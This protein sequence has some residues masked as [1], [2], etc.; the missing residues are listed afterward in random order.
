VRSFSDRSGRRRAALARRVRGT[1]RRGLVTVEASTQWWKRAVVYQVYPRSF[2]DSDGDGVGDLR[3]VIAKLDYLKLLGVDVVWLSPVYP[4]PGDDNGYDISDYCDIAPEFGTLADWDELRDGLHARGMRLVM[5]LVVN[6]TSDDHPW[7]QESR[8]SVTSPRRDWYIWRR[9]PDGRPPNNWGSLFSGSAWEYDEKT[10]EHYLHLFS[11]RMPD[12][13]WANPHVRAAV[14][15]VMRWWLDRG[16]DGFRMDVINLIAKDPALPSTQPVDAFGFG[17]FVLDPDRCHAYLREVRE[18]VLAGRDV[19]TIGETPFSTLEEARRFTDPRRGELDM[20][21]P[22]DHMG[23]DHG[24]GG[25]YDIRPLSLPD[26]KRALSRWQTGLEGQGWACLYWNNHDQPRAVS[27]FGDDRAY[28][29]ESAKLLAT[30]LYLMKG[31]PFLYQGEEIGMTNVRFSSVKDYRDIESLGFYRAAVDGG[32]LSTEQALAGVQQRGRDNARTPMQWDATPCAGFTTGVPWIAVNPN[33]TEVNVQAAVAD[34]G[35]VFH[36]YRRLI[37]LRRTHP[38]VVDGRYEE[39]LADH[40]TVF[41]YT[42]TLGDQRLLVVANWSADTVTVPLAPDLLGPDR[43]LLLGTYETP[44]DSGVLR[45][46]EAQVH[47]GC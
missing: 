43:R 26:L 31:T 10:G 39:L 27:R 3:G 40:Q 42:R 20:V 14:H 32:V 7:F 18:Q 38:V 13:N 47:L 33:H 16:A 5:D 28:R 15:D 11:R 9:G 12:L 34:P 36:H 6:H 4:S 29:V 24:P 19:V 1:A 21:I 23:V 30:V 25:R 8:T 37:E 17:R 41:A 2:C 45:P 22:F 35:S 44:S 46:W